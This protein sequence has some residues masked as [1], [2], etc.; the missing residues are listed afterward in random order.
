MQITIKDVAEKAGV[1]SATVSNVINNKGKVSESTRRM[2]QNVISQ[3]NYR[4]NAS[5]Q[6]RYQPAQQSIGM[7]I[8]ELHNPYFADV[9]IGAQEAAE[10]NGYGLMVT[11][12]EGRRETENRV[13]DL[14]VDKDVNGIIINPLL[15]SQTDLSH[16]FEL[17][18]RNIP[19]VLLERVHG[20]RASIVDVDNAA[21]YR[22]AVEYLIELGHERII[23]LAGPDYS[24]HS[25]E[26][27]EGFRQAF[28]DAKLVFSKDFIVPAGARIEDGY[29]AGRQYF[30]NTPVE[31]APTAFVCYND[32]VALGLLRALR[33]RGVRVPE[34]VSII[35][36]DDIYL[37]AYAAVPLTTVRVPM[38]EMGRCAVEVL[39]RQLEAG[40]NYSLEHVN[41]QAELTVR[42]STAPPTEI[43]NSGFVA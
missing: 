26:R 22:E 17:K 5:A 10:A 33:E 35:G 12:S 9:I 37:C 19:F 20:L 42:A 31:E 14:F 7:V 40:G 38:R 23:H 29:H 24:M 13:V 41:L 27:I 16:L 28:F 4:P 3:L 15:D 25:D 36:F 2:V 30:E 39:I 34:D 32:L 8:K 43:R 1:S 21:A 6:R 18:R 11:S